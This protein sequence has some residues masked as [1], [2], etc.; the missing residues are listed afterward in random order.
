MRQILCFLFL[1]ASLSC[2]A[3][4]GQHTHASG[5]PMQLPVLV[6][7]SKTPAQIPDNLAY[8][9]LLTA[10]SVP[11]VATDEGRNRQAA[12]L[13]GLGLAHADEQAL[14]GILARYRTAQ[15]LLAALPAGAPEQAASVR[16]QVVTLVTTTLTDIR[17]SLTSAGAG[18]LDQYVR[19]RVKA[20]IV[21]YG[22]AMH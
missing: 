9:H 8:E 1:I 11:A 22:G 19:T 13:Y 16:N 14:V 18:K 17:K 3:A 2:C 20:H 4:W 10:M 12:Q 7:G 5:V 6:D 21:I 15:D